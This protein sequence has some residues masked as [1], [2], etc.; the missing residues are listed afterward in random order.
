[1][2][3]GTQPEMMQVDCQNFFS[4][5]LMQVVSA[6]YSKSCNSLIF[7]DLLQLYEFNRLKC[8]VRLHGDYNI[9]LWL[10]KSSMNSRIH[11]KKI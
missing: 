9:S 1:M 3:I 2:C 10:P 7:T 5:S 6:T 4:R 8:L 11:V